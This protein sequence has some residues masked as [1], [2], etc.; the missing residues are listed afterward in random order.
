MSSSFGSLAFHPAR[1][2]IWVAMPARDSLATE[3]PVPVD[4]G[5]LVAVDAAGLGAHHYD[6][7]IYVQPA[8]AVAWRAALG[9][10]AALTLADVSYGD[11]VLVRLSDEQVV[12]D[13]SLYAFSARFLLDAAAYA[14]GGGGG[15]GSGLTG[16]GDD[17]GTG[18]DG[19]SSCTPTPG[20]T[21]TRT[22]ASGSTR[23][24]Y[25]PARP[26]RIAAGATAA[27]RA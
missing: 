16:G 24:G 25:V 10:V 2:D 26:R 8:D 20:T 1:E 14:P 4:T 7:P 18:N 9:T 17:D 23:P 5:D 6:G 11:A 3:R 19:S 21:A 12:L 27:S 15:A 22:P 13:R